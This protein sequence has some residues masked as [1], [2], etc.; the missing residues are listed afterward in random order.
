MQAEL[1]D[2]LCIAHQPR[3]HISRQLVDLVIDDAVRVS[4]V[5]ISQYT[6]KDIKIKPGFL[7]AANRFPV[8]WLGN[9]SKIGASS[10]GRIRR[11][12]G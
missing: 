6:K 7:L 11:R 12:G 3:P 9:E 1:L 10:V 8:I 2:Q 5:H 4:T